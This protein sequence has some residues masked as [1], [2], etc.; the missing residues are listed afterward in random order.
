MK[1]V[2][3]GAR[4][5]ADVPGLKAAEQWV[6]IVFAPDGRKLR[7]VLPGAEALL[8]WS[9]DAKHLAE[10][11]SAA[12]DLRWVH[13]CGAGVDAALFPAF[14]ES[15]VLLTNARGIYD[16]A[17]AEYVL[18]LI[19]SQAKCLPETCLL[20]SQYEWRHRQTERTV[21]RRVAVFGVGSIGRT[22][23]ALL[24]AVGMRVVGVGR[25]SRISDGVFGRIHGPEDRFDVLATA[26]WVVSVMPLTSETVDYFGR[27][28]FQAMKPSAR[29]INVGRG[30]SVDEEA[31]R[32]ALE[33]G[34][35]AGAALDVFR[36]EPLAPA[37]S[38]WGVSNLI[39]SPHMS[40]DY[41]GSQGDM[42]RQ[43]LD[44]LHLYL[45]AR[46]LENVVDK[47]IGYGA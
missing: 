11:F 28:E 1:L 15:D 46:P 18:C 40:G 12:T 26:D 36:S 19:L 7:E 24:Q 9:F 34:V 44:N 22:I 31:L 35:I 27:N 14:V 30:A 8:S 13:W 25:T 21:E 10:N 17:I 23:G 33:G 43:F 20:Q 45:S 2:V 29:F 42:V 37:S 6:D 39:I 3:S 47:K 32:E 38:L 4:H 16:R 5:V 41:V